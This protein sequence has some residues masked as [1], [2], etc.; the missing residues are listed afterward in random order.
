MSSCS[1]D[2]K[3]LTVVPMVA[4]FGRMVHVCRCSQFLGTP[5][6]AVFRH[7]KDCTRLLMRQT[8]AGRSHMWFN[9]FVT[10]L[11]MFVFVVPRITCHSSCLQPLLTPNISDGLQSSFNS[12]VAAHPLSVSCCERCFFFSELQ[13]FLK[14]WWTWTECSWNVTKYFDGKLWFLWQTFYI[15]CQKTEEL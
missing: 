5:P 1:S 13:S 6:G 15:L 3:L 14:I 9:P 7:I 12:S 10:R 11:E 4:C 8:W 2:M